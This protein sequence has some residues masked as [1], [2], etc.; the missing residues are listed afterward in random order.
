MGNAERWSIVCAVEMLL[1]VL[2]FDY[3]NY[4]ISSCYPM[5]YTSYLHILA[6]M[7]DTLENISLLSASVHVYDFLGKAYYLHIDNILLSRN[8]CLR[9]VYAFRIVCHNSLLRFS[10]FTDSVTRVY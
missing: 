6:F 1:I 10:P 2:N 3:L 7:Q 4:I 5:L 8:I 9:R